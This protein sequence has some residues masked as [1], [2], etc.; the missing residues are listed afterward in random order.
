MSKKVLYI[1]FGSISLVLISLIL[2]HFSYTFN[3]KR[4][5]V[6]FKNSYEAY[7]GLKSESGETYKSVSINKDNKIEYLSFGELEEKLKAGSS[8]IYLSSPTDVINRL[9]V[10]TIIDVINGSKVEKLY[11][12]EVS[13][14]SET[15][16]NIVK[17]LDSKE[18]AL[19]NVLG[20]KK[21]KLVG[22]LNLDFI[23]GDN[24][25]NYDSN[26]LI[27]SL[28]DVIDSLFKEDTLCDETC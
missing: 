4:D 19:P 16:E 2:W 28:N 17:L 1:V 14:G 3:F 6:K 23:D 9:C 11:Y 24:I 5:S 10:E 22:S 26:E 18:L 21:G 13:Y 12:F 7:N 27:K 8:L 20:I 25:K 15:Y